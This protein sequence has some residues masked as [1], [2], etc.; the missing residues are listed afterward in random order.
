MPGHQIVDADI[1]EF[2]D[3][4]FEDMDK[5]RDFLIL[6]YVVTERRDSPFWRYVANMDI[7]DSVRQKI[8][9]FTETARVFRKNE[10]L[11]AENSWIQ[12]MMG[13]GIMPKTYHPIAD[14]MSDEELSYFLNKIKDII[15]KTSSKLPPHH[16]YVKRYCGAIE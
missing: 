7:P 9:L 5:I 13:Q 10:E 6:H 2:N 11:F 12:V 14:K 1:K 15:A 4:T 3:Q 8:N 16:E